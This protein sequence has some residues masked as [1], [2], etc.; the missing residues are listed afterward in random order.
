[1]GRRGYLPNA[2][3]H[4]LKTIT[5]KPRSTINRMPKAMVGNPLL[6]ETLAGRLEAR[7]REDRQSKP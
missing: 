6:D 3:K 5:T 2:D 7:R 1:M 4:S